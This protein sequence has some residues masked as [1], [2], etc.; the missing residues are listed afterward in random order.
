MNISLIDLAALKL[1]NRTRSGSSDRPVSIKVGLTAKGRASISA[2]MK[3]RWQQPGYKEMYSIQVRGRR[4]HTEETRRL[5]SAAVK[6]KWLD[7]DY[8]ERCTKRSLSVDARHKIS[9]TMKRLWRDPEYKRKMGSHQ[10]TTE[11]RQR[12]SDCIRKK[13]EDAAY[14]DAVHSALLK[15]VGRPQSPGSHKS[16]A[17]SRKRKSTDRPSAE[18]LDERAPSV[19]SRTDSRSGDTELMYEDECEYEQE[20]EEEGGSGVEDVVEVYGE[21]G[22]LLRVYTVSEYQR[23][24]SLNMS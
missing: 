9:E 2:A 16:T 13:W 7:A 10:R 18:Q 14:R 20:E 19:Q 15:R 5:I 12:I 23:L 8:R 22:E 4:T 24:R 17:L 11:W 21:Y 3:R 1:S 6:R